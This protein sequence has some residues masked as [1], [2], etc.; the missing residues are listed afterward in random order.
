MRRITRI[1]FSLWHGHLG[2]G[3]HGRDARATSR[4]IK[5]EALGGLQVQRTFKTL[6]AVA[7]LCQGG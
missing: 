4:D 1:L 2:R 5:G 7:K 3:L 6:P